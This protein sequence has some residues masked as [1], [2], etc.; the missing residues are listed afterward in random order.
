MKR[1]I[2]LGLAILLLATG[3]GLF[4]AAGE[5]ALAP[6]G[7]YKPL[8]YGDQGDE[9]TTI[10]QRLT[11]L[12]YY[13]GKI[14]GNFLEGTQYGIK[15]FQKDYGLQETGVVDG[16]TEAMLMSAEYRALVTNSE[17]P[18]VQRIQERLAELGYYSAKIS[19]KYL[20]VTTKAIKQFQERNEL[21]STGDADIETQKVL[22]SGKAIAK[23]GPLTTAAPDPDL[24][25]GDINDVVM[26][27]DGAD[28]RGAVKD[29]DY[30]KK[31]KRGAQGK[32]V[33]QVQERLTELGFYDGP[34]SGNY[35]DKTVD[36]VKKFQETNSIKTDGITGEET[37]NLL[38]N[39][40][41]VLNASSTP[42]P[43]PV[44]TPVP[45]AITVDVR[46]QVVKVYGRD[47]Q[48]GYTVPV[49]Q[50]ICSTGTK[51]TPSD[52][53][54]WVMDGRRAR[55]CYFSLYNSHA[56]YWVRINENI[57]FHSVIYRAVDY[58][59]M[60]VKSY[61]ML[62]SRASHGCIRLLVSEAK[63]M[64]ENIKEGV[65]CTIRED[66][67]EDQE[68]TKALHPPELNRQ[69]MRP[70]NTPQP[71]APPNYQADQQPPQ[72]FRTLKK[73][74][75]GEDVYWLQAKL[76]DLG[77]Y[78]GTVTGSYYNGTYQAVRA[79]QR[80]NSIYPDG[81]AGERTLRAIYADVLPTEVPEVTDT[82]KPTPSPKATPTWTLAPS[83]TP[84][85]AQ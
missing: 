79:F 4:A 46:N 53:G 42:R 31:L 17:G 66:L 73:G 50:M 48:G 44:P 47:D 55:W 70:V 81:I 58:Q 13:S 6:Q 38:F 25:M 39:D 19:G 7:S 63:W 60:S 41:D 40:A 82:P 27:A 1:T 10:Q 51:A 21:K 52:V 76:K 71:T 69:Y 85:S 14:S 28:N 24:D 49:R 20:E 18:E 29:I 15:R 34:I 74:K 8:Q 64:Y 43:T 32:N 37:W 33:K 3:G 45:Y 78:P 67:P 30:A 68:L 12:G 72:P 80:A 9:V 59:A 61:N 56:Q 54:D 75:Q 35:M 22:F 36:S 83:P 57:A 77:F 65:V 11:D 5:E 23:D 62:G 84:S 2:A 26:V 16:E